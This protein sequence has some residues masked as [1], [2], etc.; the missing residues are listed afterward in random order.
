[1]GDARYASADPGAVFGAAP[2]PNPA[3]IERGIVA[4]TAALAE[5]PPGTPEHRAARVELAK[6]L[7]ARYTA[8]GADPDRAAVTTICRDVL[9]DPAATADERQA[10]GLIQPVLTMLALFRP[11]AAPLPPDEQLAGEMREVATQADAVPG[12][13]ELPSDIRGVMGAVGGFARVVEDAQRPEW[14]GRIAPEHVARL[15]D[16]PA[17]LPGR[18]A[19]TALL[20]WLGGPTDA[21]ERTAELRSALAGLPADH[22]LAPV[23][24]FDLARAVAG[25]P[26]TADRDALAEAAALLERARDGLDADDPFHHETVRSL[27]GVL[28][29]TAAH[30]PS[31]AAFAR[32][33]RVVA[34]LLRQ[35]GAGCCTRSPTGRGPQSS[36][37]CSPPWK[38]PPARR[39][40]YSCRP[41]CSVWCRGRPRTCPD[42]ARCATRARSW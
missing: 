24:R 15:S 12:A 37:R 23:L 20:A 5:H 35:R 34:D 31:A 36:R 19:V 8:A 32:V 6:W 7:F 11:G 21:E 28:L 42:Q 1:M 27:A 2:L 10:V 9:A 25:D 3:E 26:A 41:A 4:A 18:E 22:L 33:E 16:L 17:D 38:G 39:A 29:A 30:T 14:D 40:W 13:A